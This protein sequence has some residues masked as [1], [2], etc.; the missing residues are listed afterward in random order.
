MINCFIIDSNS[1]PSARERECAVHGS[2]RA[3]GNAFLRDIAHGW[4]VNCYVHLPVVGKS[5]MQI[6]NRWIDANRITI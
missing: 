3:Q 1:K 5:I 6:N 2:T 4:M